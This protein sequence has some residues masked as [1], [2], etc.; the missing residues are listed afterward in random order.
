MSNKFHLRLQTVLAIVLVLAFILIAILAEVIAPTT[1]DLVDGVQL[2]GKAR[3]Q[4]PHPPS[5]E[6]LLGTT[7]GQMDIFYALVHGTRNALVF[8]LVTTLLTAMIGFIIGM[9]GGMSGGW[10]NQLS[11]RFTDGVLCFPVIAG[12]VFFQQ[13][14]NTTIIDLSGDTQAFYDPFYMASM[15]SYYTETA[16]QQ[17]DFHFSHIKPRPG[18]AGAGCHLLG[19]ICPHD[20]RPDPADQKNG[21]CYR[22]PGSRRQRL[23]DLFPSHPAQYRRAFDRS[24]FEGYRPDGDLAND[25]RIC[26]FPEHVRLDRAPDR[27]AQLDPR[28]G[29][30]SLPVLVGIPADH[31]RHHSYL[32]LPGTCWGM[33][34]ITG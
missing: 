19:A 13:I 22:R 34:S 24:D 7:P 12:I 10:V 30:Q 32:H 28:H 14:I 2:A 11:M 5:P 25:F 16:K 9:L 27:I 29:R 20:E 18:H 15:F 6:A 1:G 8:G 4:I 21:V 23:A 26:G 33:R 17:G 3:D 31:P